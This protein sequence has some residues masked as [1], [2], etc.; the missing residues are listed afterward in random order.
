MQS[1]KNS[2]RRLGKGTGKNAAKHRRDARGHLSHCQDAIPAW[3]MPLYSVW[4][5]V[6]PKPAM[7]D[8]IIVD[9]ASQCGLEALP[10]FY[11][12]KKILIIGDDQQT[13]PEAVGMEQS[14][15]QKLSEEFLYD[16]DFRSEF[17][18]KSSLFD[19]GKRVFTSHF[20][21]LR[22]HFRCVPEIIRFSNELCYADTP[23]I[24]LKQCASDRL[25][26]L[27]H[28]YIDKGYRESMDVNLPEAQAIVERICALCQDSHYNGK[29]LG[30]IA[31]QGS[32]QA[33]VIENELRQQLSAE[34]IEKR[35]IICGGS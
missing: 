13:S 16:S 29:T 12:G 22:E 15:I 34:E 11:L 35:R 32:E 33:R 31:L 3:I 1:W 26:P 5:T 28:V 24:P 7:F 18:I 8:V 20:V 23:L 4:D 9:E 19:H 10:L 25:V 2:M 27:E 21:T 30:V 6:P 14:Q 17:D